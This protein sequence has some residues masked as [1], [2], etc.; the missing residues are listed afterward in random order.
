MTE[1]QQNPV[2]IIQILPK[3]VQALYSDGVLYFSGEVTIATES[4]KATLLNDINLIKE[5]LANLEKI[6]G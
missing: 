6:L 2:E 4:R 1:L 3:Y 5:Q